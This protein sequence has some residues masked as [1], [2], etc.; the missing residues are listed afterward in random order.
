MSEIINLRIKD[1]DSSRMIINIMD[2]KGGKDRQVGLNEPL[3]NQL[4]DYYKEYKPKEYLFEG[5]FEPQYSERSIQQFLKKYAM[6]AGINKHIHPH[7]LRHTCGTH[8][9]E[10]GTDINLIQ[11]LFGHASVKTTNIYLHISHNHISK[12]KSPLTNIK[13]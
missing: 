2:A 9:V 4:R 5:Q 10:D 12:I 7:L 8:M 11:K 3:L 13:L 6:D 1:V